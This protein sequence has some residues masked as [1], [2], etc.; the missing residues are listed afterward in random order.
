MY[1]LSWVLTDEDLRHIIQALMPGYGNQEKM[2]RILRED[3]DFLEKMIADERLFKHLLY[4]S[5][6]IIKVSP[7]FLFTV[8]LTRVRQD[9]ER[10]TYTIEQSSGHQMMVFDTDRVRELLSSKQL[11]LYLAT[12]LASF[13]K[14][15]S[16]SVLT[17]VRKG[18]WRK[19]R[20]SDFDIDSLIKYSGMLE[21]QQRFQPYRRIADICLFVLGVFPEHLTPREVKTEYGHYRL[22]PR[23]KRS[24][25]DYEKQGRYFYRA[26]A[27][28]AGSVS[29]LTGVLLSLSDNF[30]LAV[31]P[32][33][34]MSSRYLGYHKDRLFFQ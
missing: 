30:T 19:L 20:F 29:A 26:A 23:T 34:Y 16:F 15:N 21:E 9:L 22:R 33:S 24:R 11:L 4:D 7:Q 25:E 31:K 6:T 13:V 18:V 5:E 1:E 14:I 28:L 10:K 12:L 3:P 2:V 17:Q 27:N 32:L 8:L